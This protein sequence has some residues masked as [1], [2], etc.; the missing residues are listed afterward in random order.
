[1]SN[2]VALVSWFQACYNSADIYKIIHV[3]IFMIFYIDT[4]GLCV[5]YMDL[6]T[7]GQ[8]PSR[9]FPPEV[10]FGS[11]NTSHYLNRAYIAAEIGID[12]TLQPGT[13]VFGNGSVSYGTDGTMYYNGPLKPGQIYRCFIR[14]FYDINRVYNVC[15]YGMYTIISL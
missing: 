8:A 3:Y 2:A 14:Y 12:G 9:R 5:I 4:F 10:I 13:F 7:G 15:I 6:H 11:Y 1:M